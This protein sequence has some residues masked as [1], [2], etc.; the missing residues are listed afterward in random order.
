MKNFGGNQQI[1]RSGLFAIS[2][3]NYAPIPL[4]AVDV[5]V[6]IIDYSSKVII[7]QV[8]KNVEQNPIEAVYS[9]PLPESAAIYGFEVETEDK[10]LIGKV[11][12]KSAAFDDYNNAIDDSQGAFLLE[13][14][15]ANIFTVNVGN[16]LPQKSVL[17]RI[18]LIQDLDVSNDTIR[19][20]LPTTISPRY[21]PLSQLVE[22][23]PVEFD[24]LNPPRI[25]GNLP[26]GL[27]LTA[28]IDFQKGIESVSS[29]S[30]PIKFSFVNGKAIVSLV[31]ENIQLNQDF[32]LNIQPKDIKT[33]S[34][35]ISKDGDDYIA[36]LTFVPELEK[37]AEENAE[38]IFLIDR[39][40]SMSGP[41]IEQAKRALLLCLHSL[42]EGDYFNVFSFGSS[43]TC[44]FPESKPYEQSSLEMAISIVKNMSADLGGTELLAPIKHILESKPKLP[45]KIILITDGQISNEIEISSLVKKHYKTTKIYPIGIGLGVNQ[46][47]LNEIARITNTYAELIHPNESIENKVLNQ[48][49]RLRNDVNNSLKINW[50]NAIQGEMI[51]ENLNTF[52]NG[53][54]VNIFKK[55]KNL[56]DEVC[57]VELS[58]KE[59]RRVFTIEI[60]EK[61]LI[62]DE[63][64]AV[65]MARKK[66]Q[67]LETLNDSYDLNEEIKSKIVEIATKYNILTSHTSFIAIDERSKEEISFGLPVY[68]RVP[69]AFSLNSKYSILNYFPS[70]LDFNIE[71]KNYPINNIYMAEN[72]NYKRNL[73]ILF[74][75][76]ADGHWQLTERVEEYLTNNT[77]DKFAF[78]EYLNKNY[79]LEDTNSVL[80]TIVI[81]YWIE[82]EFSQERNLWLHIVSKGYDW[83]RK[84]GISKT[85]YKKICELFFTN[86]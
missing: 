18:T 86:N 4:I 62:E 12:E 58:N 52:N 59:I 64:I 14:D 7:T 51:P 25:L 31:G 42:T 22:M 26:Y 68:R 5:K 28:D 61:N 70:K 79:N 82:S 57:E 35:R 40:G 43:F 39:S 33:P 11:K 78:I 49:N 30:H 24:H 16:L 55:I 37:S 15:R 32:I 65:L 3:K 53:V 74:E 19:F 44:I 69:I 54:L 6:K 66:I 38:I 83:L 10:K 84:N 71:I 13:Q 67:L 73:N 47:A 85:D 80:A 1:T 17:I 23:D 81:I 27:T 41:K 2:K 77:I 60:N 20:F 45:R 50:G 9:F 36:M 56:N 75:Q 76:K 48:F 46:Y 29:P 8:Y 72:S 21:T 63:L 34:I